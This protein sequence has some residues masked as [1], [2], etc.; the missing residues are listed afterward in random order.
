LANCLEH[1]ARGR[2]QERPRRWHF[3]IPSDS[4]QL[5]HCALVTFREG[6]ICGNIFGQILPG[7]SMD[8]P[9]VSVCVPTYNYARFLPELIDSVLAQSFTDFEL[10]VIDDHSSD[11]TQAVMEAY[12]ERDPR[13]RFLRNSGNLGMV[14]NWNLCLREARGEYL[15]FVFGD[16]LL[17]SSDA[18]RRMVDVLD[19]DSTVSLIA[20]ARNQ[21]DEQ[22]R[23]IKLD[24]HFSETGRHSGASVIGRCLARQKNLIGEPTVVM[25]RAKDA[26]RGFSERYQHIVDLE[27]WFHLLENGTFFFIN[28]PLCSFRVHGSQQTQKNK[29]LLSTLDD[30]FQLYAE[31]LE[32]DYLDIGAFTKAY[33]RYCNV[34][35][36]WKLYQGGRITKGCAVDKI[37]ESYSYRK[38]LMLY[39]LY[40]VYRPISKL[41]DRFR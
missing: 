7:D 1:P 11:E 14:A 31:Y 34:Y 17:A 37:S 38:F 41:L 25:F 3:S 35:R 36:I 5:T 29:Y 10:L 12:H 9:K 30:N 4:P 18:L 39:P 23:P 32:T 20:S 15:K 2:K 16:D 24:S 33:V 19:A 21:V 28:E 8:I 22:S 13:I 6:G 27:M 26:G 40:K